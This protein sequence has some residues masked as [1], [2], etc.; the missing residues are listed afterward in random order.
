MISP[1]RE[2]IK[3]GKIKLISSSNGDIMDR[4]VFLVTQ[5][6]VINSNV[7][8]F[9]VLLYVL[10]VVSVSGFY[11]R[12]LCDGD[13]SRRPSV[14]PSVCHTPVLCLVE[15]KQDREMYTI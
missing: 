6:Y 4:Y 1:T 2:L 8:I 5:L 13:V 14:C 7:Q 15:R 11:P 9:F 12:D 10:V 3:E